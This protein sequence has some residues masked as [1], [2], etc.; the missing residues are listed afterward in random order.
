[1]YLQVSAGVHVHMYTVCV[2]WLTRKVQ[3]I[4]ICIGMVVVPKM[5][6]FEV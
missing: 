1:M 4:C 6:I 2:W 5:I 3:W